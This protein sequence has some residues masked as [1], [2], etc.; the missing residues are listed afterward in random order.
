MILTEQKNTEE[1]IVEILSGGP[2]KTADLIQKI[3]KIKQG[4]TKQTVYSALRKLR[5]EEVVIMYKKEA[6]LNQAWILKLYDFLEN[7]D[8]NYIFAHKKSGYIEGVNQL[9]E[10]DK[11]TYHFKDFRTL[12]IYWAHIFFVILKKVD[13][14]APIFIF[15]PHEWFLLIRDEPEQ[16]AFEWLK[17]ERR[18]TFL[19]LGHETPLDK[20][21]V[22]EYSSKTVSVAIDTKTN[23]PDDYY[24]A[25]V[26]DYVLETKFDASMA[27]EINRVYKAAQSPG[28]KVIGAVR[29]IIS[30]K[31][32]AKVIVS[33]N[34]NKA[35]KI[36]KKLAKN[37]FIPKESRGL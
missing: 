10:G 31:Y 28:E 22:K 34:K 14:K 26:D 27:R 23:Y 13:K 20:L 9:S 8:K 17:K 29:E 18:P 7:T 32:K 33:K 1:I 16:K 25:V 5:K 24:V 2:I 37:F 3:K 11:I 36:K 21:I 30:K 4:I 15:N 6:M 35:E 12:D 19:T